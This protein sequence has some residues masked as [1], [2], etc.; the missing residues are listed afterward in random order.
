[1]VVIPSGSITIG[2]HPSEETRTLSE[3]LQREV[4]IDY[5]FA[6]GKYEV[7]WDEW[8]AC[9]A[10]GGCSARTQILAG[11]DESWGRGRL[12]VIN[13]EWYG[14]QAYVNWLSRKTEQEYR[15]LSEAEWEYAARAGSQT[16]YPWGTSVPDC[17]EG[18][19]SRTNFIGCNFDRTQSVGFSAPNAFGLYDMHG[20]VSEWVE[21]C[22]V[23]ESVINLPSDGSAMIEKDCLFRVY[24]GGSFKG[25][26]VSTRSSYRFRDNPVGQ[27]PSLGFRIAKPLQTPSLP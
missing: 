26:N 11:G 5:Q 3:N 20:N 22:Y 16:P 23:R 2:S 19:K 12:P 25:G 27:W 4:Q 18:S 9:V 10:D 13:V 7:T 24:K 6:V 8:D 14:A 15:L 1:M 21:D 17:I